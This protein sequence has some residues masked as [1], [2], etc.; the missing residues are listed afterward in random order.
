[1]KQETHKTVRTPNPKYRSL[2]VKVGEQS[3][4]SAGGVLPPEGTPYGDEKFRSFFG[5]DYRKE[6]KGFVYVSQGED[7]PEGGTLVFAKS[8]SDDERNEPFRTTTSKKNHYWHPIL[9][10]LRPILV[11]GFPYSTT[12][13]TST[14]T[15]A[16]RYI[17]RERF[18]PAIS[19]GT[20]FIEEEFTSSSP[21]EIGR[22]PVP[23]PLAITY[24][25]I[26]RRGGFP[27]SLHGKITIPALTTVSGKS[28]PR[29]RFSATN[30]EVW[31]PYIL[32]DVQEFTG[33]VYY[34]RRI[35]VIPPA[36]PEEE[37]RLIGL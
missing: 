35:K 9:L 5:G 18:I 19:E 28:I 36:L 11:E 33:G 8:T 6:F 32:S 2:E 23:V 17:M 34:R 4:A 37:I 20:I 21:F 12:T 7:T 24:D 14:N 15:N 25:L 27:E 30:F 29:Q 26:G 31:A 3:F 22:T 13:G 10:E 16:D 1:M